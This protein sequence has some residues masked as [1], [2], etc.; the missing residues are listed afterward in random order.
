MS[1]KKNQLHLAK[2]A[3]RILLDTNNSA[4]SHTSDQL[5][6]VLES[7][8]GDLYI[9][10]QIDYALDEFYQSKHTADV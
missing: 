7:G 2:D 8:E 10:D 4:S 6:S 1:D 9:R 5:F 3:T